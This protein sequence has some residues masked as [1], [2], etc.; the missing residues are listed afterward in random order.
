MAVNNTN[1]VK[2]MANIEKLLVDLDIFESHEN[3]H[4]EKYWR[5]EFDTVEDLEYFFVEQILYIK[6]Y[7]S[8]AIGTVLLVFEKHYG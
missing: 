5:A 2:R 1:M 4:G 7:S 3:H 6:G 8:K